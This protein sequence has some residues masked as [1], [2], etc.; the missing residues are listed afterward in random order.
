MDSLSQEHDIAL[1]KL[2]KEV[3]LYDKVQVACLPV[4][5]SNNYPKNNIYSFAAGNSF[6]FIEI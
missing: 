2:S 6:Y 4:A 1:L 3:V 5:Q